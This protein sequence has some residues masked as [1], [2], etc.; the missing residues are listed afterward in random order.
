MQFLATLL[1]IASSIR[2]N[3]EGQ[4]T[5]STSDSEIVVQ[6]L[7]INVI[8][9]QLRDI[10][11]LLMQTKKKIDY[12]QDIARDI[13]H[14]EQDVATLKQTIENRGETSVRS[15]VMIGWKVLM[16]KYWLI[17]R[18]VVIPLKCISFLARPATEP[19][20]RP[21]PVGPFR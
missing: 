15:C 14:I 10:T 6:Q 13:S 12:L 19:E 3:V 7:Q 11:N 8:N 20:Y 17:E 16:N 1:I 2:C 4:S 18:S 9:E 21:E 5:V